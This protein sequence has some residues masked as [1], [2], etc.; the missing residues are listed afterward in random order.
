MV[1]VGGGVGVGVGGGGGVEGLDFHSR[2]DEAGGTGVETVGVAAPGL[3]WV[4]R[5]WLM[6]LVV[7][8][9]VRSR[10]KRHVVGDSAV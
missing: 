3:H 7:G 6:V 9:R 8:M 1:G 2:G 5:E 10:R 4:L